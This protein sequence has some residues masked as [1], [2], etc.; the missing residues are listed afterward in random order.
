MTDEPVMSLLENLR[1]Y[2][3]QISQEFR[4]QVEDSN[5][6]VTHANS[7]SLISSSL[8]TSSSSSSSSSSAAAAAA[9]AAA[10]VTSPPIVVQRNNDH[11]FVNFT[12]CIQN[13]YETSFPWL[14][15]YGRGGP[16]DKKSKTKDSDF[17]TYV[18]ESLMYGKETDDRRMQQEPLYI[19]VAHHRESRKKLGGVAF[20]ASIP[21]QVNL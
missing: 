18:Q 9:A 12:D 7:V 6:L 8:S 4:D 21:G 10:A 17:A 2:I 1:D 14:F 3:P 20:R 15:P 11:E 19:F 13:F 5:L 16:S